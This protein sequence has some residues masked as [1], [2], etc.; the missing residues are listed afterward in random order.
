MKLSTLKFFYLMFLSNWIFCHNRPITYN[1]FYKTKGH[2]TKVYSIKGGLKNFP[3]I[4]P[5]DLHEMAFN[6][7]DFMVLTT[8]PQKSFS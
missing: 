5:I 8:Q 7:S 4:R 1:W 6:F 3:E 2:F